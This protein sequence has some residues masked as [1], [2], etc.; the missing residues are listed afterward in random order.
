AAERIGRANTRRIVRALEV[1]E[2][3]GEP[4]SAQ[5][6]AHDYEI[7]TVQLAIAV[8]AADLDERIE[9]RTRAMF[10]AG[11]VEE[12]ER[13][14]ARGLA[15]G[16]TAARAVGYAQAAAVARGESSREE[17]IEQV[18]LATRQLARRQAK[19]F[20]RDPRITWLEPGAD[21]VTRARKLCL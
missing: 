2:L 10:A 1:I 20:R 12:T 17:A 16:R 6:P 18:A 14:L 21:L 15:E 3:T 9:A 8:P 7:E 11:L 4:F 5:L 13:L 19:W